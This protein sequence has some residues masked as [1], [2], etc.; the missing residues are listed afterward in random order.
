V[1]LQALRAGGRGTPVI[2]GGPE[3]FERLDDG[4]ALVGA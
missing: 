2:L 3:E 1:R 4:E